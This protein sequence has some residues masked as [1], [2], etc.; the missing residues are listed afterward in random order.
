MILKEKVIQRNNLC[1][2]SKKLG[3]S[4]ASYL[5][6]HSFS[7]D[8]YRKSLARLCVKDNQPFSVVDDVGFREFV[9]DL[10]PLFKFPSRW[11]VARD[12]LKLYKEE[13]SQLKDV[14]KDQVVS[15]TTD[16]WTSI[17]NTNYSCLTVHWVDDQWVL[18]KKIL[19]FCKIANHNGVTIGSLVYSCL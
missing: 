6:F 17:Q 3:E 2:V 7:Q 14:L 12:C 18:R 16:T 1:W 11:T 10:Q 13:E 9:S 5:E 4:G 8:K 15:I 19:N